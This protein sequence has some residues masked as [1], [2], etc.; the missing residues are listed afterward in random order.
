M[1][2]FVGVLELLSVAPCWLK[3]QNEISLEFYSPFLTL[4][5]D[6]RTFT[7]LLSLSTCHAGR[8][9]SEL[10]NFRVRIAD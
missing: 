2:F 8:F 7:D 6:L 1:F 3:V 4:N 5:T 9:A 10:R